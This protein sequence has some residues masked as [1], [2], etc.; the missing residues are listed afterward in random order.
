MGQYLSVFKCVPRYPVAKPLD[1]YQVPSKAVA[2]K[3]VAGAFIWHEV[4]D[5]SLLNESIGTE[6]IISLCARM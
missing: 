3:A 4:P 1:E 6:C 2:S 5:R